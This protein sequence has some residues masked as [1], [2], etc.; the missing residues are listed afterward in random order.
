VV[1]HSGAIDGFRAHV[2]LIPEKG[3]GVAL[4]L[5]LGVPAAELMRNAV[6]DVLLDLPPQDWAAALKADIKKADKEKKTKETERKAQRKNGRAAP[7]PLAAFVGDYDDPAYGTA[8]IT[9]HQKDGLA[10]RW[11]RLDGPLRHQTFTTFITTA[12]TDTFGEVEVTFD[13]N[14]AGE[15][16]GLH[17][18]D[19]R[20]A[21]LAGAKPEEGAGA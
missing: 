1:S 7:L 13:L 10:L 3:I 11:N 18:F 4:F 16:S 12:G 20:F 8:I 15:I 5:N 17:L 21:R 9:K 6:F 14:G 2:A 19:G